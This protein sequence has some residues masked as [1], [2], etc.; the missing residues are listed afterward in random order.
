MSR[1]ARSTPPAVAAATPSVP[2]AASATTPFNTYEPHDQMSWPIATGLLIFWET[3]RPSIPLADV[4][5][6]IRAWF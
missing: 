5:W 6:S 4:P 3:S 1:T 2:S